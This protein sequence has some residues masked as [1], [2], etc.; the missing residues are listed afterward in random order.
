MSDLNKLDKDYSNFEDYL[1]I[2][3]TDDTLSSLMFTLIKNM[4]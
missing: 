1:D 3:S 4:F 2:D